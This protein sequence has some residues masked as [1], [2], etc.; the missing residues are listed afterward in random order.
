MDR[1]TKLDRSLLPSHRQS[2]PTAV[3]Q[4]KPQSQPLAIPQ[5]KPQEPEPRL[6]IEAFHKL[7]LNSYGG[8]R[9]SIPDYIEKFGCITHLQPFGD[10]VF[11]GCL[12]LLQTTYSYRTQFQSGRLKA[13]WFLCPHNFSRANARAPPSSLD[14]QK[15]PAIFIE[16]YGPWA[17]PKMACQ[18]ILMENSHPWFVH[19]DRVV[20]AIYLEWNLA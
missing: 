20:G 17:E 14:V 16:Y 8:Y 19:T 11:D 18:N 9:Y 12:T 2:K 10:K 5:S 3:P 7:N 4:S 1:S 13:G 15:Y 6:Y